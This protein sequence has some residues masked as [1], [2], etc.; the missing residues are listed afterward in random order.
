MGVL[1]ACD[2]LDRKLQKLAQE[3]DLL[4][5]A[6]ALFDKEKNELIL[7]REEQFGRAKKLASE[8]EQM[9]QNLALLE[10]DKSGLIAVSDKHA[11]QAEQLASE[12]KIYQSRQVMETDFTE[13]KQQMNEEMARAEAQLE[14]IKELLLREQGL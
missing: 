8:I 12:L 5:E 14:L 3:N 9:K 11:A 2:D 13:R 4:K 10:K 1:T 7:A 6:G